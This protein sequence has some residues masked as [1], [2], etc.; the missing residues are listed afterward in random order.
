MCLSLYPAHS[1]PMALPPSAGKCHRLLYAQAPSWSPQSPPENGG[2]LQ[3]PTASPSSSLSLTAP[4]LGPP[5]LLLWL[6]CVCVCLH[7]F[8]GYEQVCFPAS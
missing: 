3:T 2:S 6:L 1:G 8:W 4:H 5:G 7:G